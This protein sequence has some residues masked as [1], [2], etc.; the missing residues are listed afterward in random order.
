MRLFVLVEYFIVRGS[1]VQISALAVFGEPDFLP[2]S[3]E[4]ACG[5]AHLACFPTCKAQTRL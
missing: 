1:S 3:G 2:W 5:N 4:L